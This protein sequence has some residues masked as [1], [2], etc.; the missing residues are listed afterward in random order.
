MRLGRHRPRR[1]S[2]RRD[3]PGRPPNTAARRADGRARLRI[4]K[5]AA[6]ARRVERLGA[7]A[8]RQRLARLPAERRRI[9]G[10]HTERRPTAGLHRV[11]CKRLR[12]YPN[13]ISAAAHVA[14]SAGLIGQLNAGDKLADQPAGKMRVSEDRPADGPGCARPGLQPGRAW[15]IVQRT[16]PLIVTAASARTCP[17]SSTT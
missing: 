4:L 15:R 3:R 9:A 8:K 2:A 11:R 16:S 6:G 12:S 5:D 7:L 14:H 13:S 10:A 1:P 17:S